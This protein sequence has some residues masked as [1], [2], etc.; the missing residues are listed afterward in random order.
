MPESFNNHG[1]FVA[2]CV[3]L[4]LSRD[5]FKNTH[6]TTLAHAKLLKSVVAFSHHY[7]LKKANTSHLGQFFQ[8]DYSQLIIFSI[9]F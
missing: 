3:L 1:L 5:D 4:T 2:I 6:G 7:F 8:A 9:S